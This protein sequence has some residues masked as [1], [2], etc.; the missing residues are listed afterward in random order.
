MPATVDML[1]IARLTLSVLTDLFPTI[2]M[3]VFGWAWARGLKR[4]ML[5]GDFFF[6]F[7]FF[8]IQTHNR[9]KRTLFI[10]AKHNMRMS[11]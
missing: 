6:F 1:L 11:G 8:D 9:L 3:C 2:H 7:F 10:R 4:L 5:Q